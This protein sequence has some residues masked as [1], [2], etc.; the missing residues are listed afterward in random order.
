MSAPPQD[1]LAQAARLQRRWR[2]L[3]GVLFMLF[4]S[5]FFAAH[6]ELAGTSLYLQDGVL[7]GAPTASFVHDLTAQGVKAGSGG[8]G[9]NSAFLLLHHTPIRLLTAFLTLVAENATTAGRH[10]VAALT[11]G[12]GALT[13]GMLYQALLWCGVGRWRAF[14]FASLAGTSM[15][16]ML[17]SGLPLPQV[18]SALGLTAAMAAVV[19][20]RS[21]RWWEFA[22]AALYSTCCSL[23]NLVPLLLLAVVRVV[24][25]WRIS[26]SLRPVML[27]PV[28]LAALLLLTL[29]AMKVQGW[30]YPHSS[31]TSITAVVQKAAQ[32]IP[33]A[34]RRLPEVNWAETGR[35]AFLTNVIA[36]ELANDVDPAAGSHARKVVLKQ[37]ADVALDFRHPL[38]SAWLLLLLVGLLGLP[39]AGRGAPTALA[40][41]VGSLGFVATLPGQDAFW[42]QAPLWTPALVFLAGIGIEQHVKRW[43][44]L[45]LPVALLVLGLLAALCLHNAR[46]VAELGRILA[47]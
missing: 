18:F 46:F 25:Q 32:G 26:G 45:G 20:G 33:P 2:G 31:Q 37:G 43:K 10:A 9:E 42:A 1:E 39:S 16:L 36:P 30:L 6:M 21:G 47:L 38:Q 29:S 28:N 13:L 12:V 5:V 17:F 15:A 35:Q 41:I 24:D 4:Y 8:A 40:L 44:I 11:A 3:G 34:L 22:A 7:A 23:F 27:L 14:L 19:R